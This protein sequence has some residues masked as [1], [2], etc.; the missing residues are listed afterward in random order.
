M[1][2][3]SLA[4]V[5][6]LAIVASSWQDLPVAHYK[7]NQ[8]HDL[9][10][11]ALTNA[12]ARQRQALSVARATVLAEQDGIRSH[13]LL[14]VP[15]YA[16]HVRCGKVAGQAVPEVSRTLPGRLAVDAKYGFAHAA[17]DAGFDAFLE[18]A[19]SQGVAAMTLHNSYNCGVLGH[20]AERIATAGALAL[21]FTNAPASIAPTG[22]TKPVI[23]TNPFAVGVPGKG[24]DEGF[25]IDQS[26][27]LVAKSEIMLCQREGK[28]IDPAWAFDAEGQP[29]SDPDAALKGS[30]APAGGYKGFG[31]G[32]LVE[33]M[34]ACLAEATLG[35]DASPFSGPLGGPPA[36][37]QCFI[38]LWPGAGFYDRAARLCEA[39]LAQPG[40]RLPGARRK[41]TR[42]RIR[43]QG[44]EVPDALVERINGI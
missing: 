4:Q 36:T 18:A 14:Y 21:C 30:M 42:A 20:H 7:L 35:K 16:E 29:T 2:D 27:S 37:G 40:A 19:K 9:A 28:S 23:G 39:I 3:S 33:L 5:L 32:L 11:D 15:I 12:G 34:A 41:A 1:S 44:V 25:V 8:I 10:L 13:G 17:I 22:G 31:I 6:G 43:E 24:S 38:G 26:A